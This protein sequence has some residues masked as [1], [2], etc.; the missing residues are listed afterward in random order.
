[1]TLF[2]PMVA[3]DVQMNVYKTHDTSFGYNTPPLISLLA[4]WRLRHAVR[5]SL[6]AVPR[7]HSRGKSAKQ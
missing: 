7:Q 2:L 4:F 1:M 5:S 6:G 3:F